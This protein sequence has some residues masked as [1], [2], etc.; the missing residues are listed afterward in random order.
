MEPSRP[1][2]MS[3]EVLKEDSECGDLD[4]GV[5]VQWQ[6]AVDRSYKFVDVYVRYRVRKTQ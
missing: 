3:L 6:W 2:R 5:I 4:V 1:G